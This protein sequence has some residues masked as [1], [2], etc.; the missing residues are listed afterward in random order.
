MSELILPSTNAQW[1]TQ[2]LEDHPIQWFVGQW[3][4]LL[5]AR[6]TTYDPWHDPPGTLL[7]IPNNKGL[8]S[9]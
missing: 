3:V 1:L 5:V 7:A 4:D 6:V 9:S 8:I 2:S